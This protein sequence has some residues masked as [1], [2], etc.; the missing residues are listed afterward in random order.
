MK[1][2]RRSEWPFCS[3]LSA[4][5]FPRLHHKII[6]RPT[7]D[8]SNRARAVTRATEAGPASES[9]QP[10]APSRQKQ[11]QHQNRDQQHQQ[12]AQHQDQKNQQ[13]QQQAEQHN[14]KK[15]ENQQQAKHHTNS[16]QREYH[17]PEQQHAQQAAWR[18]HRSQNWH[19]EHRNWEQRGG[20]NGYRIPD[21]H[22]HGHFG[23]SHAFVIY[24]QPYM[25]VGGYP[26]FQYGGY[27]FSVVDPWP[28]SWANNW[29]QTDDVYVVYAN[30]G[31][32]MYNRR[33]PSVGIAISVSM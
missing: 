16:Q 28:N 22:Y 15:Q 11:A 4:P 30:N 31:Y 13:H 12:Q 32:Y 29:Y 18:E 25:V 21:D 10:A 14:Q 1:A 8:R 6:R 33:H 2:F 23:P 5:S 26:R 3:R 17:S 24:S 27:W 20:Y 9:G 7:R 19:S